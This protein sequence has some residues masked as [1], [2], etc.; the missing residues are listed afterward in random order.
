MPSMGRPDDGKLRLSSR[1]PIPLF[2]YTMYR[3]SFTPQHQQPK[4]RLGFL[5]LLP[6]VTHEASSNT[7]TRK[8]SGQKIYPRSVMHANATVPSFGHFFDFVGI[9]PPLQIIKTPLSM[10]HLPPR[11]GQ[12]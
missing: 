10:H 4:A 7:Y 8:T 9:L 1:T 5:H 12:A 11:E 2:P 6:F 3:E